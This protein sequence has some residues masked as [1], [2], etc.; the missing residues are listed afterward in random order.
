MSNDTWLED[1]DKEL[2]RV[3]VRKIPVKKAPAP[4]QKQPVQKPIVVVKK[5]KPKES[6]LPIILF[7]LFLVLSVGLAL[8]VRYKLTERSLAY[9]ENNQTEQIDPEI[10]PPPQ[11]EPDLELRQKVDTLATLT[12]KIWEKVKVN[13][14]RISLTGTL[15]NN[16]FSVNRNKLPTSKYIYINKNWTINK[17]PDQLRLDEQDKEFLNRHLNHGSDTFWSDE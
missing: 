4:V 5:Q 13:S 10:L 14:D 11:P 1:L 12:E 16:N 2:S 6:I 15:L 7:F 17:M 3:K 8:T 9:A